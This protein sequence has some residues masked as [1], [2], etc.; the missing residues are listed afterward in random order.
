[1]AEWVDFF[2][3]ARFREPLRLKSK[4]KNF[5]RPRL[6]ANAK[7][8]FDNDV[9]LN[10]RTQVSDNGLSALGTALKELKSLTNLS[11]NFRYL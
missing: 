5:G 4:F 2:I 11:L 10:R 7:F 8:I 9:F 6:I 3:P 1:M